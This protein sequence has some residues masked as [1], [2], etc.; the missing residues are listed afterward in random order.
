MIEGYVKEM[1][2]KSLNIIYSVTAA[3]KSLQSRPTP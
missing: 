1:Y 2:F 3:A